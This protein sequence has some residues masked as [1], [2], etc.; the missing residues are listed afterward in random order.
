MLYLTDMK[1][2]LSLPNRIL[3]LTFLLVLTPLSGTMAR[4]SVINVPGETAFTV[5]EEMIPM[6]DGVRLYTLIIIP[7]K[8]AGP[9]PVLL[10]RTPYN[11][12][13]A[14]PRAGTA[15][16]CRSPSGT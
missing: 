7:G 8:P 6:R 5:R 13:E 9:L 11:A 15:R 16:P 2:V 1:T 14:T 3:L 10:E 4:E 12:P